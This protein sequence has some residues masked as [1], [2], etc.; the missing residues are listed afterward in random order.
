[1]SVKVCHITSMHKP[2]D[3]RI[4]RKQCVSLSKKY[5]VS[6]VQEGDGNEIVDGISVYGVKMPQNRLKRMLTVKPILEKALDV[7]ADI[8]QIHDPELLRIIPALKK[9]GKKVIFD[10]HENFPG[11]LMIKEWMPSFMRKYVSRLYVRYEKKCL[12]SVDAVFSVTPS[13]VTRLSE[14]VPHAYLITNYPIFRECVDNR[15]WGNSV[16]FAG[17]ITKEW[18]HHSVVKAL[19]KTDSCYR[20]VGGFAY[21]KYSDLLRSFQGWK[22]VELLGRISHDKVND[23]LQ[24]SS[25]AMAL[26]TYEDANVGYM[27]GTLGN[28]KFFEYMMAGLPIITS[29]LRLWEEVVVTNKCGICVD[30]KDE[31][32]IA[33]AITY[34]T[35]HREEAEQ[36]GNRAMEAVRTKYNWGTQ[37]P[38]LFEAYKYVESL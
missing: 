23:F 27:E 7:D 4:F 24:Q 6:L 12:Q 8:Y 35:T 21:K 32:A 26:Y 34:L 3:G 28:Q 1:M 11:V 22:K 36:M 14:I 31:E 2:F 20:I 17:G 9:A 15:Q 18:M 19:E 33:E 13:I 5:D 16:C 37:E 30:P 38:V 10:S 25:A 29:H